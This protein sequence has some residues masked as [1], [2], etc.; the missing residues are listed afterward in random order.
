MQERWIAD[1]AMLQ[2]ANFH[3]QTVLQAVVHFLKHYGLP[4]KITFDRDPRFVGAATGR[5]FP[6]PLMRFLLCL[7][8]PPNVCWPHRASQECFCRALPSHLQSGVHTGPLPTN[9]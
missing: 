2:Q 5:D 8:I 9:T 1:R 7:G 6:S 3:A 4:P